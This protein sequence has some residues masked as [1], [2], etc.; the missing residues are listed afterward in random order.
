MPWFG[1]H[2]P[3]SGPGLRPVWERRLV[4]GAGETGDRNPRRVLVTATITDQEAHLRSELSRTVTLLRSIVNRMPVPLELGCLEAAATLAEANGT[5][6]TVESLA[7]ELAALG[8]VSQEGALLASNARL[9][10]GFMREC[11]TLLTAELDSY[12]AA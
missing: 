9:A 8:A 3:D 12:E 4:S 1:R 11:L 10:V 7:D 6:R 2:G 5:L